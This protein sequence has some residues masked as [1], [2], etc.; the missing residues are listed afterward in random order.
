MRITYRELCQQIIAMNDEQ[1]DSNVMIHDRE[2]AEFSTAERFVVEFIDSD[3]II[4]NSQPFIE[5]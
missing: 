4:D 3:G 2:M 1:L 5:F